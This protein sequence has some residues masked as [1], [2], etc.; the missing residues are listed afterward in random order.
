VIVAVSDLHL[1]GAYSGTTVEPGAFALFARL[2]GE[3]AR[4]ASHRVSTGATARGGV[5]GLS[6]G[7]RTEFRPLDEGLDLVLLGD[8]LDLLRSEEWPARQGPE[9]RVPRPWEPPHEIAP[10]VERIVGRILERNSEGLGVLRRLGEEGALFYEEGRAYRVPVRT[11]YFVG[12]HDWLLRLPGEDYDAVRARV[13]AAMGLANDPERPFP[14]DASE[15]D[16]SLAA[17]LRRHRLV[18]RHGDVFDPV[19]YPGERD[20]SGLGDGVVIEVLNRFPERVRQELRL[21]AD[22]PLFLALREVD[23]VRPFTMIPPWVLGVI[24]RFGLEGTP[25]GSALLQL[26]NRMGEE[27]FALDFVRGRDRAWAL[28]E[29]DRLELGF[30]FVRDFASGRL[31]R[32]VAGQLLRLVAERHRR[33]ANHALAEPEIASAEALHVAYGHTHV[34]EIQALAAR[35]GTVFEKQFYVNCGTWRPTY[36][37]T[38]AHPERLDFLSHDALTVV[39]FYTGDE[40]GGRAFEVWHGTLAGAP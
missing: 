5:R 34:H 31:K 8:I 1:T 24:R 11:A 10:T 14:H 13:V 40:R 4:Q 28:D 39:A 3:M 7:R 23:N 25:A 33:F 21:S 32:A 30:R 12:N 37:Q 38:L 36:Q 26:W 17:R 15:A 22:D 9:D 27:F 20:S 19:N 16:P 2:L 29:V 18:L 35:R 6:D